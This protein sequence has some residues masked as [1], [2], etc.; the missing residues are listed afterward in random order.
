MLPNEERVFGYLLQYIGN[1]RVEELRTFLRYVTGS[2]VMLA[3]S[4][5]VI[6]NSLS[7][8]ARRPIVHTCNCS[9]NL[10]S[11]YMSYMDFEQEFSAI[12]AD[13]QYSWEMHGV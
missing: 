9:I 5:T 6:F 1:M 8:F 2:S 13:T 11:T 10:P 4:L 7:G 12:L 3:K